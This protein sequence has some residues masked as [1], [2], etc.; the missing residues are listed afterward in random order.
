V[1][2]TDAEN[3]TKTR[4][5]TIAVNTSNYVFIDPNASAGGAGTLADP[6]SSIGELYTTSKTDSTWQGYHVYVRDGSQS[7]GATTNP[8]DFDAGVL[9]DSNQKVVFNSSKPQVF[10]GYP[11]ESPVF[12]FKYYLQF[13]GAADAY[14]YGLT[15]DAAN[16]TRALCLQYPGVDRLTVSNNTFQNLDQTDSQSLNYSYIFTTRIVEPANYA[17]YQCIQDN[18]AT[19]GTSQRGYWYIGYSTDNI[20]IENNT[21]TDCGD[22][23]IGP[24]ES[25]RY[26]TIRQ[27]TLSNNAAGGSKETIDY[28]YSDL[29]A[30]SQSG[31]AE[32]CY[33]VCLDGC[34]D[35]NGAALAAGDAVYIF[36]NTFIDNGDELSVGSARQSHSAGTSGPWSWDKNVILN[37]QTGY[38]NSRITTASAP[39][40]LTVGDNVTGTHASGICDANGLL[41]GANRTTYLGTHGHEIP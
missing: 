18:T 26:M 10:M 22:H 13:Q 21:V 25:I 16:N 29:G 33:N 36:R 3:T 30:G 39:E 6:L 19:G 5:W 15:V 35:M 31:P 38:N 24:K 1:S 4:D 8:F 27:N 32:I 28:Q 7:G 20:L 34:C 23:N 11:G 2:V 40:T 9:E 41:T 14:F 37:G 17:K 12:D